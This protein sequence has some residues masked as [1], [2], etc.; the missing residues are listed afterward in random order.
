MRK[1]VYVKN[2]SGLKVKF[3][4]NVYDAFSDSSGLVVG[5][6]FSG[7]NIC[8]Q[9]KVYYN[10]SKST[11]STK[12]DRFGTLHSISNVGES[13]GNTIIFFKLSSRILNKRIGER[14]IQWYHFRPLSKKDKNWVLSMSDAEFG[15]NVF[16]NIW[17]NG[18]LSMQE[19]L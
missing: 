5:A 11:A 13:L 7:T 4:K 6:N 15:R 2:G 17:G 14:K 18:G 9:A 12:S 16:E 1:L 10:F 19:N 3:V 8:C